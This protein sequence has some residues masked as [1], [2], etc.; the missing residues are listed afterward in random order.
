M[1]A[2]D[3]PDS[4]RSMRWTVLIVEGVLLLLVV[5]G[6]AVYRSGSASSAAQAKADQLTSALAA[7]GLPAPARD[8]IVRVL[9]EDGGAV[10]ADPSGALSKAALNSQ[11]S[12]GA[13]GP[14][15]RPVIAAGRLVQG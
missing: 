3:R 14:G 10:C 9:G 7:A 12:N 15:S 5:I 6:L 1:T 8:Q 11:L 2:A 13:G 4:M